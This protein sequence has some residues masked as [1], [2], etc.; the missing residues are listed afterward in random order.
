[1]YVYIIYTYICIYSRIGGMSLAPLVAAVEGGTAAEAAEALRCALK[2]DRQAA[3]VLRALLEDLAT[4][5]GV[6]QS[7]ARVFVLSYILKDI[8]GP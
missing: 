6:T 1:M 8:P 7:T 4:R 5:P 3:F 2:H